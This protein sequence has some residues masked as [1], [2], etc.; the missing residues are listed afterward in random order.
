MITSC[1]VDDTGREYTD[2][3]TCEACKKTIW[4]PGEKHEK[5]TEHIVNGQS[6]GSSTCTVFT[7]NKECSGGEHCDHSDNLPSDC[8]LDVTCENTTIKVGESP[9]IEVNAEAGKDT[10]EE[11]PNAEPCDN[12]GYIDK[13]ETP[14]SLQAVDGYPKVT[15]MNGDELFSNSNGNG[16]SDF[17][18]GSPG[19]YKIIYK[20]YCEKCGTLEDS[21]T[22]T[23]KAPCE[24]YEGSVNI[25][26]FNFQLG[27]PVNGVYD[28]TNQSCS[29]STKAKMNLSLAGTFSVSKDIDGVDISWTVKDGNIISG[30]I[31]WIGDKDIGKLGFLSGKL[32]EINISVS[33]DSEDD[34]KV[35]ISGGIKFYG[36]LNQDLSLE[37]IPV[38]ILK[39]GL[40]GSVSYKFEYDS[41]T[42]EQKR[43]WDLSG[44]NKFKVEFKKGSKI[45][46]EAAAASIEVDGTIKNLKVKAKPDVEFSSN[47][48]SVKLTE[49]NLTL[50]AKLYPLD[51]TPK[52]GLGKFIIKAPEGLNKDLKM[53]L[54]FT[55]EN[56]TGVV[57]A[58][59]IELFG[60][61]LTGKEMSITFDYQF[62]LEN[63]IGKSLKYKHPKFD[64]EVDVKKFEI[65]S[66][67]LQS[68]KLN[69]AEL[70]YEG[71]A[72]TL[73]DSTYEAGKKLSLSAK[74]KIDSNNEFEVKNFNINQTS[75]KISIESISVS[76]EKAPFKIKWNCYI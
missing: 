74:C 44:L 47:G 76:I 70:K 55:E 53:S 66:G 23:V 21:V 39:K 7:C 75:G 17:S 5:T 48:Y 62:E 18:F 45:F 14:H 35:K 9:N 51:V 59:D 65:S 6:C 43:F 27:S 71:I 69:K 72:F 30:G 42:N 34:N 29:Y 22:I 56:I 37:K 15:N 8:S 10:E 28:A 54:S 31:S 1:T 52:S 50:D 67:Q 12:C 64:V 46:A 73:S 32:K 36:E 2:E 4:K 57:K 33:Q 3:G 13:L 19:D 40:N 63:I 16:L 11:D 68:F 38:A 24:P 49:S 60:G 26:G 61:K 25:A 20:Y 41:A 58:A